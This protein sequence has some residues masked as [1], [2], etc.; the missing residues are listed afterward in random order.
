[1]GGGESPQFAFAALE[2]SFMINLI[3]FAVVPPEAFSFSCGA[4]SLQSNKSRGGGGA[5]PLFAA[6]PN[7]S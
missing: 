4:G 7:H 1:M 3:R 5:A 6:L 2:K